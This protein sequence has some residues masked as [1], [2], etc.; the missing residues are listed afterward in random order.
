MATAKTK[1][2]FTSGPIFM[3]MLYF[4]IPVMLTSLL[5]ELYNTADKIVVGQ[6]SGNP[7]ALAAIGST[8]SLTSLFLNFVVGTTA[9]VGIAVAHAFGAG[10]SEKLKRTVSTGFFFSLT[11]GLLFAIAGASLCKP[12]LLAMGTKQELMHDAMTYML[13][14]CIGIPAS[15]IYNTGAA[16]LRSTGDSKTPLYILSTT[17]IVNVILNLIFVLGFGMSVDGVAIATVTA[18]YL[19]ALAIIVIFIKRRDQKY[20]LCKG[21]LVVDFSIMKKIARYGLPMGIQSSLFSISNI[22]ITSAMN[23]FPTTTI[24]GKAV[25]NSADSILSTMLNAYLHAAMTFVGQ[26][27]GAKKSE[28]IKKSIMTSLLQALMV[29]GV[30]CTIFFVFRTPIA[31]LYLDAN[32][33]QKDVVLTEAVN[34]MS[35]MIFSYLISGIMHVLAGSMR[36]LGYS[37]SSMMINLIATCC[38]R[39]LWVSFLFPLNPFNNII[40]LLTVYPI[41]WALACLTY[42]V[43]IVRIWKKI[44]ERCASTA[45]GAQAA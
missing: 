29:G 23:T 34:I 3:P 7:N 16:T 39:I 1:K 42:V 12:I 10:E 18:K 11:L 5:Q 28:R 2:N 24:S 30:L 6:F 14:N 32:D 17:G 43:F 45:N 19:S 13:I 31:S 26:N 44:K 33:P 4:V 38:F 25:A 20:S 35:F 40:G 9:G 27:L 22:F 21:D 37:F 8:G 36:G 15:A 41:S